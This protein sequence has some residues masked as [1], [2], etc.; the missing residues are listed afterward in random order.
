MI[1]LGT[2]ESKLAIWQTTYIQS[3]LY[4]AGLETE[5]VIIKS[6]GD[7]DLVSPLYELG[8]QGIF[9]K[10]LDSALLSGAIDIAVHSLKDVPT[11][12]AENICIAAIP[13]RGT[14]KDVLIYKDALQQITDDTQYTIATSSLRRKAQWLNKYPNHEV[15]NLR[16]NINTRLNKLL[17]SDEWDGAIFA[18]AGIERINLEVPFKKELDWMLP[19]PAQGALAIVCREN[20]YNIREICS[21]FNHDITRICVNAERQFLRKLMGGCSMPIGALAV[22][23]NNIMTFEGNIISLDGKA[24][25]SV[26]MNFDESQFSEAGNI[27]GEKLLLEG[28]EEIL[29]SIKN[30]SSI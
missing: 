25:A 29:Q 4:S 13:E 21:T 26:L 19:A 2:R 7:I 16:G 3:L 23:G 8:I 15:V 27:G 1:K 11:L 5:I 18:A 22:I 14:H 6:D 10:T 12:L 9:T 17:D 24:K 30:K 20:D 28:G